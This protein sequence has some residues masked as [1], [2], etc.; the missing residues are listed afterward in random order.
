MHELI[1]AVLPRGRQNRINAGLLSAGA[2]RRPRY[3]R[4]TPLC[5]EYVR[6][7]ANVQAF[8]RK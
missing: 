8:L 1:R 3:T 6:W 4:C 5:R 2:D 7:L